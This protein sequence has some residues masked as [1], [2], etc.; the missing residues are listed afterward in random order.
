M[1]K[2]YLETIVEYFHSYNVQDIDAQS[3]HQAKRCLID[4]LGCSIYAAKHDCCPGLLDLIADMG[5]GKGMASIWGKPELTSPALAAFAN[6]AR[7]SNIELDD[8]SAIGASVHPGVYV[9]SAA[10]AAWENSGANVEDVLRAVVFGYDVCLRMGLMAT[11]KVRE[12]GLHGPGLVGGLGAAATAG[13]LYGLNIEQLHNALALT[14]SLLPVCPFVS[15]LEGADAKDFYG[16]WGA[17]LGM[18]AV[19]GAKKG[20]T[21]PAHILDGPKSL[22]AIFA[23]QKG[24]DV[25][26]GEHF[27]IND[28][29]F[30]EF[31]ACHSVHPAMTVILDL[32]AKHSIDPQQIAEITVAT[33][34]YS[35]E[36]DQGVG[37]E[38]NPSSARLSLS[39][40]VAYA[41]IEG[42]L[43]PDAFTPEKL[44]DDRYLALR[45]RV[46]VK[47]YDAYGTGPF[48]IRGSIVT[49]RMRDGS[50]IRGETDAPRWKD[51][52]SDAALVEKYRTLTADAITKEEQQFVVDFVFAIEKQD[53]L[54]P[55]VRVLRGVR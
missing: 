12:L 32:Q 13:L 28:T 47:K 11:D 38:L 23:G 55:L 22:N 39:Y 33:Y 51:A 6:A 53:S 4:Y 44:R 2:T 25:K 26:P 18:I 37:A 20:L 36:L 41:L 45:N 27:F 10:L 29:S 52:P 43:S 16:G 19:E 54:Q 3:L 42:R 14:A 21:G 49:I 50:V 48:G 17:Y 46:I 5:P 15:F 31:S 35:Y 24:T 34:P 9:W 30:K 40:T 8:C 1:G 7:T